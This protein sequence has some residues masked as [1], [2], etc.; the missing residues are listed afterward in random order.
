MKRH[1]CLAA[2]LG[3]VLSDPNVD[4]VLVILTPQSMTDIPAIA[5]E[6]WGDER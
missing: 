2:A 3:A 4:E 6:L 5:E 1:W